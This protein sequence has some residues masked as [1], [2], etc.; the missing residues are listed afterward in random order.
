MVKFEATQCLTKAICFRKNT[1]NHHLE[2]RKPQLKH[3]EAEQDGEMMM[4][5]PLACAVNA[6]VPTL[7][8]GYAQPGCQAT[9]QP[10]RC[11]CVD[12]K[13]HHC[14][15]TARGTPVIEGLVLTDEWLSCALSAVKVDLES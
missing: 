6:N 5:S 11:S 10:H 3:Q 9:G 2:S 12:K 1:D 14:M 7:S 8:L 4:L 13:A 15:H